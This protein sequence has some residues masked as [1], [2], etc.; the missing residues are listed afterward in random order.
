M[1]RTRGAARLRTPFRLLYS[2][3]APE[4]IIYAAELRQRAA[5]DE[6]LTIDYAYTR[7][8]PPDWSKPPRRVDAALLSES[9]F[10]SARA[11]ACY[12]CGP[13]GFVESVA[14]LL[15]QIGYPSSR[16]KTERFGPTGG[17]S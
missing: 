12:V 11:P 4:S 5:E 2:V 1:I 7:S 16:I 17:V 14:A 6:G 9:A 15:Q 8:T 10:P 3:R 13:T